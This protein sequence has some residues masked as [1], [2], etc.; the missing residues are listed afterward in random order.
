MPLLPLLGITVC[1]GGM[2]MVVVVTGGI[3]PINPYR[4]CQAKAE[5]WQA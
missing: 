5:C 1:G 2:L 4:A 3:N